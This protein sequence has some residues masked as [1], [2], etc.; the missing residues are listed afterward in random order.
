V[1]PT[2]HDNMGDVPTNLY[3]EVIALHDGNPQ[4]VVTY[5]PA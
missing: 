4:A 3:G 1:L 5:G 2:V